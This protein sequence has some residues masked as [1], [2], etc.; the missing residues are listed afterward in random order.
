[1]TKCELILKGKH[2]CVSHGFHNEKN[3]LI[4]MK[5]YGD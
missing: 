5:I 3:C 1:M 2:Y 4:C